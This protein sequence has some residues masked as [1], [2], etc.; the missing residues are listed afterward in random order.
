M[1][2][3]KLEV[4]LRFLNLCGARDWTRGYFLVLVYFIIFDFSTFLLSC[5]ESGR[6]ASDMGDWWPENYSAEELANG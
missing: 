6:S 2:G 1:I 3:S 4:Y 5:E